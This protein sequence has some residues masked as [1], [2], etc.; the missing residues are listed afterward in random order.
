M[1]YISNFLTQSSTS[2]AANVVITLPPH[3]TD[4]IIAVCV[5]ADGGGTLAA[6]WGG[7]STGAANVGA[8]QVIAANLCSAVFIAKATGAAATL[9]VAM[10][11]ADAIHVHTLIIKDCDT[12][13]WLDVGVA[14]LSSTANTSANTD[15]VTTTTDD[16]LVIHYI[17]VD[18]T[19]T[20]VPTSAHSRPGPSATMH[21]IDSSD[22]G[23][24]TNTT[25]SGASVGW[26]MQRTAAATPQP[27]WDIS[28][29][30]QYTKFTFALR[31]KTNG[32][33]PAYVDDSADLGTQLMTGTW[34]ASATT[35]NNQNFKATP[36]TYANIGANGAGQG[37]TF[38]AGAAV[39]D[40]G[41]NPYSTAINSTP[42]ADATNAR[43]FEVG[44]PT[45]A[46][47]MTTGWIVGG[48]QC[49][50]SKMALFNQGSI[51]QG[52]G[53]LVIG[54]GATNFRAFKIM[55][56]DN[57]DGAGAGFTVFS[58]QPN[59]T[60]TMIGYSNTAP[61]ITAIDKVLILN[62]GHNT[63]G[64]FYYMDFH[65]IKKLILAGGTT[66]VPVDTLGVYD[67][68]R[69]CRIP[70][71]KRLGA[72]GL[73]SY[74]PIQVGGGDA[75][76]IK[77]TA[78]ALQFPQIYSPTSKL[79]NYHGS[80]NSIGISLAGKSGD[81]IYIGDGYVMSTPSP[82]YWEINSAATNAAS[83][84]LNGLTLSG[85]NV[86]LRN[87][88]TFQDIV[89]SACPTINANGCILDQCAIS[90][91]P[92]TSDTFSS[93]TTTDVFN[94]TLSVA[95]VA[96][97]N[98]WTSVSDPT[99]FANNTFTGGGANVGGHAIRITTAGTYSFVGN[100]FNNFGPDRREF[101]TNTAVNG[102]SDVITTDAAHLYSNGNPV[103]Y[104]K[105]GSATAIGLTDGTLY[106]VNTP[107]STQL[108]FYTSAADAIANTSR[109]NL[110]ANT[111]SANHYFYSAGAA[112]YNDSGG[113][114]T[115]NISGG[116]SSPS[117]RNATAAN[118]TVNNVKTHTV[119]GLGTGDR[120]VWIRAS[121]DAELE[122]A[123]ETAGSASYSYNYIS[124]VDVSVQILSLAR[125]NKIVEVTLGSSDQTLPA[126]L[127]IDPFFSNPT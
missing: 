16:C 51:A 87:V 105:H 64:A 125:K 101:N 113:Q 77:L 8:T 80:N 66:T 91:V 85:F 78:G 108:A 37:T 95:N 12:T 65:L 30:A 40:A 1:P 96:S 15:T 74:V 14:N 122:N 73:L 2:G 84:Y 123:V 93:N 22:N 33:I 36:L 117:Y 115:L 59:Q 120:V 3:V 17:G 20:T 39:V 10:G 68:G 89:F 88:M 49:S 102:T 100:I 103:Y 54:Q 110:T 72:S 46:V 35:R 26:Y 4:D 6:T 56:R 62:K 27:I 57:Q 61:T 31:N 21:F 75:I 98:R 92:T 55:A 111:T 90:L 119:T 32:I 60:Q 97:S 53:Y 67:I 118:T 45:T 83:W 109:I 43:G 99:I 52:G 107:S 69:F 71:V 9:G 34:W 29:S 13:T 58:V 116:G 47:D 28:L 106:Y 23:G 24:T 7:N 41:F 121:D 79:I 86:T 48:F 114:V 50:T 126:S 82:A 81:V 5:T 11:T 70:I 104:Q 19:G 76:N 112:I 94:S 63:T 127:E 44:F 124:D 25:L 18:Q 38:D 42:T